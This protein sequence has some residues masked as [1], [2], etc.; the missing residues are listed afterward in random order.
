MNKSKPVLVIFSILAGL[1]IIAA[2]S[3]LTDVLGANVAALISLVIAAIQGGLAV[4]TSGQVTNNANVA[5]VQAPTGE[6]VAGPAAKKIE[7]GTTVL[8]SPL[9]GG[10]P[11]APPAAPNDADFVSPPIIEEGFRD[12]P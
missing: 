7:D 10:V 4:Y 9:E 3:A 6:I 12:G 11:P 5:A 8:V 1:Q 2:G